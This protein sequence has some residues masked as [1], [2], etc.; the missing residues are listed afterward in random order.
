MN[1]RVSY[2]D[3][4]LRNSADRNELA[5]RINVTAQEACSQLNTLY[6]ADMYPPQTTDRDCVKDA[7]DSGMTQARSIPTR[8]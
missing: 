6:P 8:N 3:L 1:R 2:A 5:R 4:N 7:V